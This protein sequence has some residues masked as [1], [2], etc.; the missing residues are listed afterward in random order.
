[1]GNAGGNRDRQCRKH[2]WYISHI[3]H[4]PPVVVLFS[5]RYAK[6]SIDAVARITQ[7]EKFNDGAQGLM[8]GLAK[9]SISASFSPLPI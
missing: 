1:V 5:V 4:N 3:R 2:D 9:T 8:H 7:P 6:K